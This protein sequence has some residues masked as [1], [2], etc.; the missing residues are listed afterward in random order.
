MWAFE[1]FKNRTLFLSSWGESIKENKELPDVQKIIPSVG[2]FILKNDR[3]LD[4][5]ATNEI[6]LQFEVLG[7]NNLTEVDDIRNSSTV[8]GPTPQVLTNGRWTTFE[9]P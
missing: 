7:W 9:W 8:L 4:I 3:T 1:L 5:Y 6:E 2:F